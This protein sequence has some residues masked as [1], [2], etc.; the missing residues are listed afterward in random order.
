[1]SQKEKEKSCEKP[2][3]DEVPSNGPVTSVHEVAPCATP[4]EETALAAE[5]ATR[6]RIEPPSSCG[7][8][9]SSQEDCEKDDDASKKGRWTRAEHDAFLRGL[10]VYGR[11]WKQVAAHI[12]TRT[13]TQVRSH[14]QKY[15]ASLDRSHWRSSARHLCKEE[16][17]SLDGD[18]DSVASSNMLTPR[19]RPLPSALEDSTM[20]DSVRHEAERILAN[21]AAVHDEVNA[22]LHQLR[23]R[24]QQLN[25]R[26]RRQLQSPSSTNSSSSPMRIPEEED[27]RMAVLALQ[28]RLQTTVSVP[29]PSLHNAASYEGDEEE[30][31]PMMEDEEEDSKLP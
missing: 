30:G 2:S 28:S 31:N 5:D 25:D 12:P 4:L 17:T 27:E 21:P 19:R 11:E 1:M 13:P 23:L 7:A 15:F 10:D 14:A 8:S 3:R 6:R 18:T 9:L 24:Y 20:S 29:P 22:T 26:R 16:E